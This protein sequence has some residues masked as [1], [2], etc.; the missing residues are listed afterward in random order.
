MVRNVAL[1]GG[2]LGAAACLSATADVADQSLVP[3]VPPAAR[4]APGNG[5]LLPPLAG[6][7]RTA[8]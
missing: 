1:A 6:S 5:A 2:L 3:D 4:V 8:R 7:R